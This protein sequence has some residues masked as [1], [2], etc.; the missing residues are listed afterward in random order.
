MMLDMLRVAEF[1][2]LEYT[3]AIG[4]AYAANIR[5]RRMSG[6]IVDGENV[7]YSILFYELGIE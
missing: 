1:R 7:L 4:S 5:K 3:N 2:Y 6:D